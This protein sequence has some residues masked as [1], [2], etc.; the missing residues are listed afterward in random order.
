ML[1]TVSCQLRPYRRHASGDRP[2]LGRELVRF[3]DCGNTIDCGEFNATGVLG[4][5]SPGCTLLIQDTGSGDDLPTMACSSIRLSVAGGHRLLP[6][7]SV[8]LNMGHLTSCRDNIANVYYV[9]GVSSQSERGTQAPRTRCVP[10]LKMIGA[11]ALYPLFFSVLFLRRDSSCVMTNG[12]SSEGT[13]K[14]GTRTQS[15]LETRH[16]VR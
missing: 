1:Y 9:A 12:N 2:Y 3:Y 15:S 13:K 7:L 5:P 4:L 14:V 8:F 16:C 11:G 6:P 10:L